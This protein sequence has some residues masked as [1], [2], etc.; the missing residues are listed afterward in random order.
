M[1]ESY[2]VAVN[3][4]A[5]I[6]GILTAGEIRR[7]LGA[8]KLLPSYFCLPSDA[9]GD[10]AGHWRTLGDVFGLDGTSAEPTR[11]GRATPP[12]DTPAEDES[13]AG[14]NPRPASVRGF[15][16]RLEDAFLVLGQSICVLACLVLVWQLVKSLYASG[17]VATLAG[18]EPGETTGFRVI[19]LSEGLVGLTFLLALFVT[20]GRARRWAG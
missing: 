2:M 12:P 11:T 16:R 8:G 7:R 18:F 15:D 19:L 17:T 14:D 6:I 4:T 20:F 5:G 1:A 9:T 13:G 3:P 10:V